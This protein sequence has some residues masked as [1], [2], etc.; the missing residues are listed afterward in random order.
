MNH[1]VDVGVLLKDP[2]EGGLVGDIEL[3]ELGTLA[4]DQLDAVDDFF[5]GV[6]QVVGEDDL[7]ASLEE[8]EGR[9]G[10]NIAGTTGGLKV[11]V[12]PDFEAR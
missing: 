8:G 2:V 6:I 7:V 3:D 1:A 5:G 9:E 11:S 4:A 12:R 10:A